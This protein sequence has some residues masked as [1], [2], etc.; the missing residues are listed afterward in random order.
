MCG[1]VGVFGRAVSPE[2][3]RSA[4]DTLATR[5][6]DGSG[7]RVL[8][9]PLPGGLGHRR[10]AI[11]DPSPGGSQPMVDA[12][13]HTSV[14]YNGEIYNF[15]ELRRRLE[16]KGA[17][18]RSDC[19]TEILLAGWREWGTDLVGHLRGIF[20]FA[21]VDEATGRVFMARDPL[22]VKP[23]YWARSG[24]VLLAGSAPR[25]ILALAPELRRDLDPIA[26]AEFLT[27]LWIPHPRT[28]WRHVHKLPPGHALLF[29]GSATKEWEFRP[30]C[31]RTDEALDPAALAEM[32]EEATVAQLLSDVP[33]GLLL[34]GGLDSTLLLA[35]M[36]RHRS[37]GSSLH[38]LTAGYGAASQRLEV[39]PDDLPYARRAAAA[40]P[41]IDLH[42]V[43]V[44]DDPSAD[45]D[46]L[47]WHFDDPVADPAAITLYRLCKASPVKVLLSG[48]GGEELFAGYPRHAG[49]A[50]A[51]RAAGLPP[52]I[53]RLGAAASPWLR[54]GTP[55]PFHGT[56]RNAEKLLRS[57]DT[58]GPVH[59]WRMM[60]QT[61]YA[62]IDALTGHARAVFEEMDDMSPR[63]ASTGLADAL[64]F[65]L[66]Q[67]LPNLNLAYVD[68][69]SM[70]TGV[71]IRV[72]LLDD[73]LARAAG[74][75]PAAS[76]IVGGV[77]KHPLR[78]AAA[79]V[80]STE[81]IKR[82]KSGFG[83]PARGWF[84]GSVGLLLRERIQSASDA[85]MVDSAAAK[86]MFDRTRVGASDSA[87]A[88]W[89]L[90]CLDTWRS[91]H[92]SD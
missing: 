7:H 58:P 59:Y 35:F 40:F 90:A 72:P 60:A 19:D 92:A 27:L 51:R 2:E 29:D 32:L 73:V 20:S 10:L 46:E 80:V 82:P 39:V 42:E 44:D 4:A 57:L 37:D 61:S 38:A 28:P 8:V 43:N 45:M 14:V 87:M 53:R 24:G 12:E 89:A 1:W 77:T 31:E 47:A 17:R 67:F 78:Q 76:L 21:V 41:D 22:G 15:P 56:R 74:T 81:I 71:E 34:S 66:N 16:A 88:A 36:A 86:A 79:G 68:K 11:L 69:A 50:A 55:G 18:F 91:A 49:L 23:L 30:R 33:V 75:A 85:G 5:G 9:G 84:Q 63:L 64:S 26:I 65:D 48:V 83:G 6:P 25:A 52:L 70:A 13:A 54:G 3:L 62:D